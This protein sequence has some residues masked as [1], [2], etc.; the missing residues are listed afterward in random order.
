MPEIESERKK[1]NLDRLLKYV[2]EKGGTLD[3]PIPV[4]TSE[5]V[6]IRCAMDHLWQAQVGSL[7]YRKTW[8]P[9]CAGN[10]PRT[11][12]DLKTII[13]KRGGTILT[14]DYRGVDGSYDFLCNLGHANRNMFKKIEK[15]Q[16]CPTCNSHSKSEE[17]T[18]TILENLFEAKF[19][20]RRP[21]WLRNSRGRLMELDGFAEEIGIAFEYQGEQHFKESTLYKTDL[22]QRILDDQMKLQLCADRGIVLLV[23]SYL[24][25]FQDFHKIA[26]AQLLKFGKQISVDFS[27]SI[28]YQSA[29]IREDRLQELR[30]LLNPKNIRVISSK[31]T[32]V[33]DYYDFQ[34][35]VCFTKFRSRANSYFNSRR[36]AGCDFCNR[37]NPRN[38][39]SLQDLIDYAQKFEGE[40]LSSAYIRSNHSY[41][42]R[43]KNG[44]V[45]EAKAHNLKHNNKFCPT[46]E[47][48]QI[49]QFLNQREAE[50]LFAEFGFMLIGPYPGRTRH[51]RTACRLCG[52]ESGQILDKLKAGQSSCKG[53]LS[54]KYESESRKFLSEVNLKPLTAY[55]GLYSPWP[56]LCLN[57]F[58]EVS[59]RVANLRRGQKACKFCTKSA[60]TGQ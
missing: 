38:K 49:K 6:K 31:W 1:N 46:C 8:C 59:P 36:V 10:L 37:R 58:R 26:R 17:I 44:H 33:D 53:C 42:W 29:Y 19:P 12:E 23:F 27:K 18:R 7:I 34:C 48:R 15:G 32:K 14:L 41:T 28:D 25:K 39:K 9:K 2:S 4:L 21:K 20:K 47:N 35:I 13:E 51:A 11:I 30:D 55:P 22:N 40:L 56:C 50:E 52:F 60:P 43:C 5:K 57:C 45:F 16:W 3:N 24:D 54:A